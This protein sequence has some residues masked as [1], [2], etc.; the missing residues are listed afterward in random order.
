[1]KQLW[2]PW[3]MSY[4]QEDHPRVKG[5]VFCEKV[6]ADDELQQVL[7]RGETCYVA[8]NRYPY[9]NGHL[10]I[11]PYAHVSRLAALNDA[12]LLEMMQLAQHTQRILREAQGPEGFNLGINEGSAAGAGIEEHLHLHIVPRWAGDANYM[13][14]IAET[15]VIP[16]ML[17]ATYALLRPYFDQLR[18]VAVSAQVPDDAA[19]AEHQDE[20]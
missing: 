11:V 13:T 20:T 8:L 4:L 17:E 12:A 6:D 19:E 1:M 9:S 14:V 15:R 10:M 5:C 18:S 3:R 16:Q 7:Y 2:A